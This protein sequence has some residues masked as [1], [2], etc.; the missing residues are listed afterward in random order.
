MKY[1]IQY[2][3]CLQYQGLTGCW[4]V[5]TSREVSLQIELS[6]IHLGSYSAFEPLFFIDKRAEK[7]AS[8]RVR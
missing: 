3:V 8:N 4:S 7:S 5:Y 1:T 2:T 6:A